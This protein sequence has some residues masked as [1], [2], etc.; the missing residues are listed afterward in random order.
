MSESNPIQ[1][2]S[3]VSKID[4]PL[5]QWTWLRKSLLFAELSKLAYFPDHEIVELVRSA[6]ITE[7]EFVERD[8]AQAYILG[9]E[10]DCMVVCRGT[11]PHEW[12]DVKA[13]ANAFTVL[14]EVGRL[15]IGFNT[16]VDDLWPMLEQRIKENRRPMWFAGHSLGGA[17][18]TICAGRCKLSK[19]PSNPEAIFTFGSPRVGNQRYINFVKIPHYRWVNNNDVVPRVPPPWLGY[20][21]SGQE[22]YIDTDGNLRSIQSWVRFADRMRGLWQAL[23]QG[24]IDYFG[25]H[26]MDRYIQAIQ[27][28]AEKDQSGELRYVLTHPLLPEVQGR[29]VSV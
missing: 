13:D 9:T 25:D 14:T 20:R 1:Q 21:H 19:I 18:A 17:M 11:E 6:G 28:A 4:V 7:C 29:T 15:H 24:Q 26:G 23:L 2:L 22:L 16:E 5:S 8:G 12:N 3:I 27:K 10:D